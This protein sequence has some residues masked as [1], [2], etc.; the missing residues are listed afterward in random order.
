[1]S[2]LTR[3]ILDLIG[4]HPQKV[5]VVSNHRQVDKMSIEESIRRYEQLCSK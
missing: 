2:R 5:A 3:L 1:M 4:Y